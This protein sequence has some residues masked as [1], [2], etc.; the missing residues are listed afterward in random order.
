MPNPYRL[1]PVSD[2][3][4]FVPGRPGR[5]A[6]A[7]RILD[8][9]CRTDQPP[10][11]ISVIGER[12][13]GK[14]SLLAYLQRIAVDVPHLITIKIDMLGLSP[15]T[16][17]GFY[18]ELATGL[19]RKG[20]LSAAESLDSY[21]G[22]Q[23][24]LHGL[25]RQSRRLLLLIDEFDLVA[26]D[27]R[28]ER[29]FFDNLRSALSTHPI[30]LVVATVAPLKAMAH[31][32]V[33]TSPFWNVFLKERL[34]MLSQPEAE[35][36]VVRDGGRDGLEE[37]RDEILALAGRHPFFLQVA[38]ALAWDLREESDG[39]LD[40]EELHRSFQEQLEDHYQYIWEHS[41]EDERRA[42]CAATRPDG[43]RP[44]FPATLSERG[45]VVSNSLV[46]ACGQGFV[47]FT[48]GK[49]AVSPQADRGGPTA[50]T[51]QTAA[52]GRQER[53][54]LLLPSRWDPTTPRRDLALV[55]GVNTYLHQEAGD[56]NLAPLRYAER[57]AIEVAAL[58]RSL[59]FEVEE[60]LGSTATGSA[61]RAV[62]ERW[63]QE[64][65]RPQ[66]P[67]SRLV[68]HFSGH[69]MIDPVDRETAYL[70]LYDTNPNSPA[71]GGLEMVRLVYT[72]LPSVLVRYALVLLDAC[73]AGYAAGVKHARPESTMLPNVTQQLFG[74][75]GRMVLAACPGEARARELEDLRHGVFTH[76]L[77]RHWRDLEEPHPP[78]RITF[79]SLVDYVGSVM[80]LKHPQLPLPVYNGVGA[81]ATLILASIPK[82]VDEGTSTTT[83]GNH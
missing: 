64:G 70:L 23:A 58:L 46:E 11:P 25:E 55:V 36:L 39:Q 47:A 12:R 43:P 41:T 5:G 35:A 82:A 56:Y 8:N 1:L 50:D 19:R 16:P 45:Y 80:P 57:D 54:T 67:D 59:G 52:L 73:H 29:A 69:G 78:D 30:T 27:R 17:D 14:S 9:L 42:M 44:R 60:L 66:H 6:Q 48:K 77:L 72:Y 79:G 28:F 51:A 21:G 20:A 63:R 81:G 31:K 61:V 22:L 65:E 62:F 33:Y 76:Y 13:F 74:A 2:P 4:Y 49:C 3:R 34:K 38:C 24:F 15:Q 18:A 71:D 40:L 10:N 68:F 26:R 53:D 32:E 7:E 75:P 83:N 37:V